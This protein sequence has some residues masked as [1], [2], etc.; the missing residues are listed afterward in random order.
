MPSNSIQLTFFK[1]AALAKLTIIAQHHIFKIKN[2][3]KQNN[4]CEKYIF[5]LDF[6]LY[7]N[8][9]NENEFALLKINQSIKADHYF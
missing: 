4:M 1:Y 5:F 2:I 8:S 7:L 3:N 6:Y 9:Y